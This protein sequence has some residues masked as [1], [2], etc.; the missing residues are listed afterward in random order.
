MNIFLNRMHVPH[1][2]FHPLYGS[3][4]IVHTYIK[5][6]YYQYVP[7]TSASSYSMHSVPSNP[8]HNSLPGNNVYGS[9]FYKHFNH[10]V[11][12]QIWDS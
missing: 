7:T 4:P 8:V 5:P 2:I 10:I 12:A 6:I 3:Y 1:L 9:P 11:K